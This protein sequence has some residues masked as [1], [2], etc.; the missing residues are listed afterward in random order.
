V[1]QPRVPVHPHARLDGAEPR[2]GLIPHEMLISTGPGRGASAP[3]YG[4]I[5][6]MNRGGRGTAG[7]ARYCKPGPGWQG[8]EMACA[9]VHLVRG[10]RWRSQY[11]R[12]PIPRPRSG[13]WFIGRDF[14]R[15]K[16]APAGS[17]TTAIS[18]VPAT[19][20]LSR[21][22]EPPNRRTSAVT[23]SISPGASK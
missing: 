2:P 11:H 3:R 12:S 14:I 23:W 7:L 17:A 1:R 15:P 9:A 18:P 10:S 19:V 8:P 5:F 4:D 20:N 21:S 6:G 16:T 13:Y 22:I